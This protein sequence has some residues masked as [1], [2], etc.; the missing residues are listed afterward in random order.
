[1][2]QP[3]IAPYGAW[4][5]PLTADWILAG[6]VGLSAPRADAA[7]LYWIELRPSEA[8]RNVLVRR[9]QGGEVSDVTPPGF[10]VRTRVHEYGGGA[11]TVSTGTVYFSNFADGRLYRQAPGGAPGPITPEAP[12][13][14]ADMVVDGGRNRLILIRE[15]HTASDRDAVNTIAAL[16]LAVGDTGQVL[17]GGN[18]FYST[19][20]LSSDGKRLAWL[21]WNHPNMPWDGTE[22]WL[23]DLDAEG[24]PVNPRLVA[25]GLAESIFQPEWS[26]DGLLHFIS[27]R[28]GWWNLYRLRDGAVE[29]LHLMEAEFGQ[30]QWAFG[31][32]TYAFTGPRDL[33]CVYNGMGTEHLAHLDTETGAFTPIELP[34][35]SISSIQAAGR[36]LIFIAGSPTTATALVELDPATGERNTLRRSDDRDLDPGY[37]SV[38]QAV[39]FPTEGGLTSHGLFYAPRNRDYRAPDRE[40]PPLLVMIH[41]GPTSQTSSALRPTIQYCASRGFAVFDVNYGGSTGYGR[42]YRQRLNGQWGVVDVD[43]CVNGARYLAEKRLV[44]P[45]RLAITGGSAGGYTTLAA[46][47]FRDLFHAGASYYG[48]SD[49]EALEGDDHKF[50]SRYNDS[51]LGPY[52]EAR[53]LYRARSPLYSAERLRR[54]VIFFQ[55]LDDP[56]VQPVQSEKM[57]AAMRANGVPVAYLAYPGEMHGFRA[58]ANIKRSLEAEFYFY[59]RIFG[60]EPADQIEPVEIENL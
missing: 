49:L 6:M 51:M 32:S 17:V 43:D 3:E 10:N 15:D 31:Q 19:P 33:Y 23:A 46:L 48:I 34:Y 18:D 60:Y 2:S 7:D 57:V 53:D 21:T 38:P 42:A 47:T 37:L 36:R 39:E 30:P 27:D 44:D 16:D 40:L 41:G 20:R 8:G 59:S 11:Y 5:S 26:P 56:V 58:A 52:P 4:K 12:M 24:V 13:R 9:T 28:S 29:P 1:M 50:E 22:L 14:Y 54:P 25:G 35:S 45:K 55:G